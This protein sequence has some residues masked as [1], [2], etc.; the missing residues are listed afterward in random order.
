MKV[1]HTNHDCRQKELTKEIVYHKIFHAD[2]IKYEIIDKRTLVTTYALRK[3]NQSSAGRL[4]VLQD[5]KSEKALLNVIPWIVRITTV[6]FNGNSLTTVI[7][8]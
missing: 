7:I 3:Q 4:G 2:T 8:H 1:R 5:S 6:Y